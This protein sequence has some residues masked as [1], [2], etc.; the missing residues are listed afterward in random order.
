L[1][2]PVLDDAL[3]TVECKVVHQLLVGTHWVIIGEV[4]KAMSNQGKPLLY[5]NSAYCHLGNSQ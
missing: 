1:G 4:E 3:A 5:F 2:S